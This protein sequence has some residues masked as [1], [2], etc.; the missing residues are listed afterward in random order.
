MVGRL[1]GVLNGKVSHVGGAALDG[2]TIVLLAVGDV[3]VAV[4]GHSAAN[5]MS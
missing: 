3:A 4:C 5:S 2:G 1:T